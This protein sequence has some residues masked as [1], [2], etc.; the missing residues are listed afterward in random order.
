MTQRIAALAAALATSLSQA[1]AVSAIAQEAP[2]SIPL[3]T[4]R[5][6]GGVMIGCTGI[7]QQKHD[8]RW[9]AYPIQVEF[10]RPDGAYLGDEA[11]SVMD[12]SGKVLA[13]VTCEGPWI[14]LRPD[15]PGEYSFKGWLPGSA[16]GPS[17]GSFHIPAKGRARIVLHFAAG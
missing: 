9:L 8:P 10:A 17:G 3:D 16:V 11:L 5:A 4:E 15:A 7:G 6:I 14:L 13:S 12:H 1:V 2:T